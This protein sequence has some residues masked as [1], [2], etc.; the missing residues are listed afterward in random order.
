[1]V[2]F[3]G[4]THLGS[5]ASLQGAAQG[6]AWLLGIKN[7]VSV[8]DAGGFLTWN[9]FQAPWLIP[10]FI[11]F[12]IAAL[13]ECNRAPFDLPEG[14]SEIIAGFHT[15]YSGF[16]FA[17][18]F[19]AEYS[20]MALVCTLGSILFLGGWNTPLPNIGAAHLAD[21]TSGIGFGIFWLVMKTWLLIF[22]QIWMRWTFPRLRMDQLMHLGWKVLTPACLIL[23]T[24]TLAWKIW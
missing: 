8:S 10:L 19:L 5:I 14:E 4:D 15:E 12:Y 7:W 20:L 11:V 24:L 2:L 21:W 1:V 16:P 9:I 13:A 22:T 6:P 18:F 17:L 3:A 23:L